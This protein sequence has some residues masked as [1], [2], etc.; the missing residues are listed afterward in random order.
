[1]TTNEPWWF[2]WPPDEEN[3][4]CEDGR[5]RPLRASDYEI[6][7]GKYAGLNLSEVHDEWYLTF[8]ARLAEEKKD[9]FLK[10]CLSLL[11]K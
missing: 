7:F 5:K 6:G 8:L 4:Y 11:E 10:K 9:W 3:M 2:M 1:M